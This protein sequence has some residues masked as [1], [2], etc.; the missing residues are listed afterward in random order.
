MAPHES[1]DDARIAQRIRAE[2][3]EMPGM[4]LTFKQVAG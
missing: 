2:Y 4:S 1:S 3:V